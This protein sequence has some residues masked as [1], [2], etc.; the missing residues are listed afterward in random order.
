MENKVVKGNNVDIW[1][2]QED[3]TIYICKVFNYED[4]ST[5]YFD[6]TTD[7][8]LDLNEFAAAGYKKLI[9][10]GGLL[11][12]NKD[13]TTAELLLFERIYNSKRRREKFSE[14]KLESLEAIQARISEKVF[15]Y[16]KRYPS[17]ALELRYSE[18]FNHFMF[19]AVKFD[20]ERNKFVYIDLYNGT[21]VP[22]D[23]LVSYDVYPRE[24]VFKQPDYSP[25]ELI[26]MRFNINQA[27]KYRR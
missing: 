22:E 8:V 24:A 16:D 19:L 12:A 26:H 10:N 4:G 21:E 9:N 5:V 23:I 14:N 1:Y 20:K 11:N 18:I 2:Y 13:Y 7:V 25:R 3:Q 6:L 17:E 27:N 15:D